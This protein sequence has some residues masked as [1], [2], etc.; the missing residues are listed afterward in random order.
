M[1]TQKTC[2]GANTTYDKRDHRD[3]WPEQLRL[4]I[5]HQNS[6]AARPTPHSVQL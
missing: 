5:L 2:S 1:K 3:W 4:E 6:E